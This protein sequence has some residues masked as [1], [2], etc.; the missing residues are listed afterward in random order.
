MPYIDHSKSTRA[1]EAEREGKLPLSRAIAKVAKTA[2]CTRREARQAL[3]EAG[4]CEW[5][6]TSS[7]YNRIDYY[8]WRP[9]ARKLRHRGDAAQVAPYFHRIDAALTAAGDK[10]S[11]RLTAFASEVARISEETGV[12]E[13]I[14]E[15]AYYDD[16]SEGGG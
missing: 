3:A 7:R 9:V 2:E 15:C 16:W 11:A 6:H 1:A 10:L 5:H 13:K 12:P 8:D 14:I 4:P